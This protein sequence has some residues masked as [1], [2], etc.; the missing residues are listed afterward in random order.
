MLNGNE[1]FATLHPYDASHEGP[2]A[3]TLN[4]GSDRKEDHGRFRSS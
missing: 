4:V 3:V 2:V 1:Q